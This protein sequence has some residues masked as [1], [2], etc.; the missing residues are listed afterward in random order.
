MVWYNI[1]KE[2]LIQLI[3]TLE[4]C[5]YKWGSIKSQYYCH[6]KYQSIQIKILKCYFIIV[7]FV[8]FYDLKKKKINSY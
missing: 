6:Q 5:I 1:R 8:L 4:C 2:F 3:L 7:H